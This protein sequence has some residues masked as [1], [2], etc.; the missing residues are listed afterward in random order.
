[1]KIKGIL[2]NE[3]DLLCRL[4]PKAPCKELKKWNDQEVKVLKKEDLEFV[5]EV[6]AAKNHPWK[7][8]LT[9]GLI[10]SAVASVFGYL[11]YLDSLNFATIAAQSLSFNLSICLGIGAAAGVITF[12]VFK[13]LKL[14]KNLIKSLDEKRKERLEQKILFLQYKL[15]RNRESPFLMP[16]ERREYKNSLH[17]FE[18][19]LKRVKKSQESKPSLPMKILEKIYS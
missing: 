15:K 7:F 11:S 19:T 16:K 6:K 14:E 10:T 1:M 17:H 18:K 2:I 5:K 12:I 3:Q 13:I 4:D 8:G 9:V